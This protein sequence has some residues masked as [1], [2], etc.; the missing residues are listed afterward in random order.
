[1]QYV[2]LYENLLRLDYEDVIRSCSINPESREICQDP[3]FWEEKAQQD[4]NTSLRQVE[5]EFDLTP[6]Q[7]YL[8]ILSEGE[9]VRGS[10]QFVEP[11]VLL[12]RAISKRR[13]DLTRYLIDETNVDLDEALV[14][15]AGNQSL[16]NE[17]VTTYQVDVF[18][19]PIILSRILQAA[20][21]E[22]NLVLVRELTPEAAEILVDR[23]DINAIL[24]QAAALGDYEFFDY[25]HSYFYTGVDP[26]YDANEWYLQI[27]LLRNDQA[28]AGELI[29]ALLNYGNYAELAS[30]FVRTGDY[31]RLKNLIR[32]AEFEGREYIGHNILFEAAQHGNITIVKLIAEDPVF[33]VDRR[34]F[35]FEDALDV[36]RTYNHNEVV[37]YLSNLLRTM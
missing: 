33:E 2:R 13:T 8:A 26:D 32:L 24:N 1:M 35:W 6:Q 31:E 27:A 17:L 12:E 28:Y 19:N 36:A 34:R 16:F 21:R 20:I 7:K 15:A 29:D 11:N 3:V 37:T 9:V 18:A 22:R 10:E 5:S 14:A 25:I 30:V 23:A 4:F